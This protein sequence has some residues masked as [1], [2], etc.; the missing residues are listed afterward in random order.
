LV[1]AQDR[2]K[3]LSDYL[4]LARTLRGAGINTEVFLDDLAL[5]EQIAYA[6]NKGIPFVVIAG[7]AELSEDI[8]S[9]R[10]IH[11]HT[12]ERVSGDDMVRYIKNKL[13]SR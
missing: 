13:S 9:I 5:R 3:Y 2:D 6:A 4:G 10:D 11:F 8:V 7:G 1:T 12:Q